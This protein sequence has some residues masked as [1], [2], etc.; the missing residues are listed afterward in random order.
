MKTDERGIARMPGVDIAWIRDP[1]NQVLSF[2][3]PN[4]HV[5]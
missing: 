1:D 5:G 3:Q 2:F 4:D